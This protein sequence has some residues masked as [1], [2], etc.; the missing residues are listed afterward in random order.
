MPIRPGRPHGSSPTASGRQALPG[1][2]RGRI[3][4]AQLPAA[5]ADESATIVNAL[6]RHAAVVVHKC[7]AG[8]HSTAVA[9]AMLKARPVVASGTA[10]IRDQI[11]DEKT[12]LLLSDPTDLA[13]FAAAVDRILADTHLA[14]D[15]RFNACQDVL[16]RSLA[17][18]NLLQWATLVSSLFP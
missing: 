4:L 3:H 9:E 1:A 2:Q 16:G 15:L 13:A 7:L 5:D 8:A 14:D 11:R 17:D 6:Q 12:G 10:G 18:R